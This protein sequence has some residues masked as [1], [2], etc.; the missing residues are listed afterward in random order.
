MSTK[1]VVVVHPDSKARILLRAVLE[2][3]G[4][5]VATDH[6]CRDLLA[7]PPDLLPH[8]VLVDRSTIGETGLDVLADIGRKWTE[9]QTMFLPEDLGPASLRPLLATVERLLGMKSTS[10][11]LAV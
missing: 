5:L 8:L 1:A 4:L 11:L 6:S 9:A 2:G 3:R 10:E 7:G